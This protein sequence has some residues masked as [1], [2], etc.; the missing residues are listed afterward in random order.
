MEGAMHW[1]SHIR[2]S[3]VGGASHELWNGM[4]AVTWTEY[5]PLDR[6]PDSRTQGIEKYLSGG[7]D[8][9][10]VHDTFGDVP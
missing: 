9:F 10:H 1:R 8:A 4:M 7:V 6:F 5:S 2:Q 3:L